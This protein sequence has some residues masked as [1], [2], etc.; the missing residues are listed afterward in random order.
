M[1]ERVLKYFEDHLRVKDAVIDK[2]R[3]KNAGLR[4]AH[5]KAEA[6]LRTKE[7]VG[8]VL[9]YIDFHQL[10]IENKQFL[11]KIE[12]KTAELTRLKLTTGRTVQ[13]LNVL[14]SRLSDLLHEAVRIRA[15][16]KARSAVLTRLRA[17]AAAVSETL[18]KSQVRGAS[19]RG[20]GAGLLY[21]CAA[22]AAPRRS[23]ARRS[24]APCGR[25]RTCR[26]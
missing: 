10:Q 12:E 20:W 22:A 18:A 11:A 7:E 6:A 26:R 14:K 16:I 25:R 15:D 5:A 4:T 23:L 19:A 8:D 21:Y 1:A 9:H 2:L 24:R 13:A 3:L 17:D